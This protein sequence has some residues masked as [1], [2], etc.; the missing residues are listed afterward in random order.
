MDGIEVVLSDE[1]DS[2]RSPGVLGSVRIGA[3]EMVTYMAGEAKP[4]KHMEITKIRC[5]KVGYELQVRGVA[6]II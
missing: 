3:T 2:N 6:L 4:H 1:L 5:W